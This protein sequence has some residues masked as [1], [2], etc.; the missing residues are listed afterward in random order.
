MACLGLYCGRTLLF[1]NS[2]TECGVCPRGM[3]T[4]A[5]KYCQPCTESP[6]IDDWLYLGFMAMLPLISHW[7]CI[8]WHS[9]KNN[10]R[11][12]FQQVSALFECF[13]AAIVTLLI[14]EPVGA[15]SMHSCRVL[16][17]SD[18]CTILV[19]T[20][21]CTQKAVYPLSTIV[22]GYCAFCLLFM[23][24]LRPFLVKIEWGLKPNRWE[25]IYAA[26]YF[27]PILTVLQA[28][29]RGL[30]YYAFPYIISVVSLVNLNFSDLRKER[31]FV[32]FNHW[33]LH[34]CGIITISKGDK[35]EQALPL[36]LLV[37]VAALFYFLTA[38]FTKP[39]QIVL[40]RENKR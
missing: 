1:K 4:N 23:M 16:M 14:S 37:P 33:F 39:S 34:A 24:L 26:L 9:R 31:L 18:W 21:H 6:E 7:L 40:Q 12:L 3:R 28:V 30:L 32:L 22:F 19:T 36:L 35:L 5:Q 13:M 25:S 38:K 2:S 8:E 11:G 20:V 10:S 29:A 27:F 15:L 17:L